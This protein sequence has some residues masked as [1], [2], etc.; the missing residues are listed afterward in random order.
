MEL[1]VEVTDKCQLKPFEMS[2]FIHISTLFSSSSPTQYYYC[3]C[4]DPQALGTFETPVAVEEVIH[5][6]PG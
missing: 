6:P 4:G 1:S 5:K 2:P 3:Y